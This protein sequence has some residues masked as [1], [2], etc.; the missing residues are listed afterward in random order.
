MQNGLGVFGIH[1]RPFL[2]N[3]PGSG[4][5]S[6]RG[7]HPKWAVNS[8]PLALIVGHFYTTL[9]WIVVGESGFPQ[10]GRERLT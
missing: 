8:Q 10:I 2:R 9:T 6:A 1:P 3:P 5:A 7:T 4:S